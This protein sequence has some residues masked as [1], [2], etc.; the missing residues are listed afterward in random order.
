VSQHADQSSVFA[1][2]RVT[3][4][5]EAFLYR[6]VDG[7]DFGVSMQFAWHGGTHLQAPQN[8]RGEYEPVR[9]IADG[10]VIFARP[11]EAP[12]AR[13]TDEATLRR[14]PLMYH[15]SW[16]SNGVIIVEH[17]TEIGDGVSVVFYSIYLHLHDLA[18]GPKDA[19]WQAG[20]LIYRKDAIGRAGWIYGGA[21]SI[22]LEIVADQANV[23]ALMGRSTPGPMNVRTTSVWGD[24]HIVVPAGTPVYATDPREGL[25]LNSAGARRRF[26]QARRSR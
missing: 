17:T 3:P 4:G 8:A 24:T 21:N 22:H 13:G 11:S 15:G 16:S 23:Q 6:T 20:D 2:G 12:P 7:G 10:K 1:A 18:S 25:G 14:H 26:D 9:A 19:P 5:N